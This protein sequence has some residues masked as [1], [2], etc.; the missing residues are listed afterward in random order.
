MEVILASS[1]LSCYINLLC[2]LAIASLN[3]LEYAVES[4][5]SLILVTDIP[6]T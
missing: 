6:S 2:C 5:I 1:R 4:H 3:R